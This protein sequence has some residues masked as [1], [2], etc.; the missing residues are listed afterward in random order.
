M[1][2]PAGMLSALATFIS[3]ILVLVIA[4]QIIKYIDKSRGKPLHGESQDGSF[5]KKTININI[6][7]DKIIAILILSLF[8][9]IVGSQYVGP[10]II[11]TNPR[12]PDLTGLSSHTAEAMLEKAGLRAEF[13]HEFNCSVERDYII[14]ETQDPKP[15][16][17]V[18][19]NSS[20]KA[21]ISLGGIPDV[22]GLDEEQAVSTLR[23]S[24]LDP[25]VIGGRDASAEID[26]VYKQTPSG[27]EKTT[28]GSKVEISVNKAIRAQNI[29][30]ADNDG[31]L[32]P[33]ALKGRLSAPL[34]G[35]EHLWIAINP[36]VALMNYYP[37]LGGPLIPR[38]D[39]AF[40][41]NAYIGTGNE[42]DIGKRYN[43]L[44]LLLNDDINE[45]FLEYMD[46]GRG[47]DDW[48]SITDWNSSTGRTISEEEMVE[49]IIGGAYN[50]VLE[51]YGGK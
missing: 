14:L 24:K 23:E 5:W 36:E 26:H 27:C 46:Y 29:S 39:L 3:S 49:S 41:G 31:V 37:Q 42:G 25:I 35:T 9:A 47:T 44:V 32:S 28:P 38:D 11:E 6:S 40:T 33:V 1:P 15:G 21:K 4:D 18:L 17:E 43:L 13:D 50:I 7:I 45:F 34:L 51:G 30:P 20:V 8:M 10:L 48:R 22:I 12:V 2:I 19:K 16:T